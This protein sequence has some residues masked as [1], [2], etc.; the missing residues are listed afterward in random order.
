MW[1]VLRH[2]CT[3]M[4]CQQLRKYEGTAIGNMCSRMSFV[5]TTPFQVPNDDGSSWQGVANVGLYS[6]FGESDVLSSDANGTHA[7]SKCEVFEPKITH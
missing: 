2:T 3:S 1:K 7:I 6:G 5:W 4:S